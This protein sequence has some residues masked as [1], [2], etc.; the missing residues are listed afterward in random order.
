MARAAASTRTRRQAVAMT[1]PGDVRAMNL[2]TALL[3]IVAIGF[4]AHNV[5][6][7]MKRSP[8]FALRSIEVVTP[9]T[10]ATVPSMRAVAASRVAG[11]FF[12]LDLDHARAAFEAVP[13]VR[14]AQVR[15]VWPDGLRVS[16]E[17]HRAAAIWDGGEGDDKLVNEYG[18]IFEANLGDVEE[19]QLPMLGG[20]EGSARQLLTMHEQLRPVLAPLQ[21]GVEHLKLS[22]RGSWQVELGN[23]VVAELGRGA[24]GGDATEVLDRTTRFV[25]TYTQVAQRFGDAK[26][27]HVDLRHVN[28]YAVQFEGITMRAP[29]KTLPRR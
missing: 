20:P 21:T 28:G 2:L 19:E 14:R 25:R 8:M 26:L 23:G 27:L 11:N 29:E 18:E 10:R 1:V 16:I 24:D 17:E 5:W 7:L 22:R 9:L 6:E 4:I 13:W 15:R 12:S 3:V